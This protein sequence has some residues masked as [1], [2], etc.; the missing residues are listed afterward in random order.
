MEQAVRSEVVEAWWSEFLLAK[1]AEGVADATLVWYKEKNAKFFEGGYEFSTSGARHYISDL[2]ASGLKDVSIDMHARALRTFTNFCMD[3]P[4]IE[5]SREIR[6]PHVKVT[7]EIKPILTDEE[8]KTLRH[9]EPMKQRAAFNLLIDTGLRRSEAANVM[10]DDLN[11]DS[12]LLLV[13]HTKA[14]RQ[15]Y[16]PVPPKT[17]RVLRQLKRWQ[18]EST[19]G[20]ILECTPNAITLLFRR[21][22]KETG[23]HVYPHK[24]RHTFATRAGNNGMSEL[25]LQ[26]IMGHASLEM[27]KRYYQISNEKILSEYYAHMPKAA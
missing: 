2:K 25:V 21:M 12:G 3:D 24:C 7:E 5:F 10:W 1:D 13:R 16:V 19:D 26:A 4:D 8:I 6:V 27:T 18:G 9:V 14:K 17:R 22:W 23:I 11:W 20:R 15:R